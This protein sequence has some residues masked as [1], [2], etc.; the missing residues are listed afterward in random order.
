MSG[1]GWKQPAISQILL[2]LLVTEHTFTLL[3]WW[4]YFNKMQHVANEKWKVPLSC[5]NTYNSHSSPAFYLSVFITPGER[6]AQLYPPY[7]SLGKLSDYM[8]SH[9][10]R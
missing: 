6:V 7:N 10:R 5:G 3:K 4:N 9:P 1:K 2:D 8:A